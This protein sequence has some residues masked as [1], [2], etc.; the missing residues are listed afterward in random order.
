ML[1][2]LARVHEQLG[3]VHARHLHSPPKEMA[4]AYMVSSVHS[5]LAIEGGL[6]APLP[7]AELTTQ[8]GAVSGPAQLEAVNTYRVHEMLPD[9]DPYVEQDLRRAQSIMLNGLAMDAGHYRSGPIEV[10]YGDPS[11]LRTAPSKGTPLAVQELLAYVESD[12]F[13]TLITSC[14]LHFGII[15]LRPFS[16]GNGRIARLWQRRL[17]MDDWPVFSY[18]PIEAFILQ[19][20]PAYH[21]A[22]EYADRRGDCGGFIVYLMERINEALHELLSDPDPVRTGAER[23]EIHLKLSGR[24][25]FRR[26]E[27]LAGFPELSTATATRDLQEAVAAGLL[28]VN[29][30]GRGAIYS[31]L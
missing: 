21:A 30:A 27:Y 19:R 4:K 29:G 10:F 24:R 9:L 12:E 23:V 22:L 13:P 17:L 11:P 28:K 25:A 14:V 15:Y 8:H 3:Q 16:A 6:M 1:E 26:K 7:L 5:T 20:E 2:L 31:P 18:L